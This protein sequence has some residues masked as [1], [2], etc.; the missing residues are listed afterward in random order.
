MVGA[1]KAGRAHKMRDE[2]RRRDATRLTFWNVQIAGWC[3]FYVSA[4]VTAIPELKSGGL[5]TASVFVV[6]T[7]AASCALRPVCAWLIRRPLSWVGLEARALTYCIPI[8]VVV[9]FLVAL[10]AEHRVPGWMEWLETAVQASFVLFVWSSLY[11]SLKLWQQSLQERERLE[12]A[13]SDVRD[14]RLNALRYQLNPHFLFNSLN[15]VSTL[16]LDGDAPSATRMLSQ[17]A[18]FLRTVFDN[19]VKP[20]T[21][22]SRELSYAEQYLAIEQ[23]RLGKRLRIETAIAPQSF[24][25]LVP[26]MLLQPLVEN[27]VRHGVATLVEG[28][29]IRITSAVRDSRLRLSIWNSVSAGQASGPTGVGPGIG[30][31]NTKARLRT[32]YGADYLLVS[33]PDAT[34][35]ETVVEV[36]LCEH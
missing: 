8:G 11:F 29:S 30:L 4:V 34:G 7:F 21:P 23:T 20:E 26:T 5:W 27:A 15:A 2:L 10:I 18:D 9:A 31:S 1:A 33:Q 35:W 17:I 24:G 3:C 22:L 19:D 14:A 36:P 32:L 16:V 28:G 25:A 6:L 12:R 13:E